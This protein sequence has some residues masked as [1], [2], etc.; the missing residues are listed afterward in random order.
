VH[1]LGQGAH[2]GKVSDIT[3]HNSLMVQVW[4]MLA[5]RDVTLAAQA[6]RAIPPVPSSTTWVTYLRCHDDIGCAIDSGDAAAVGLNGYW[7]QCFLSD[8]YSGVHPGS[9]ARAWCSRPIPSRATAG[10]A[11]AR[12]A[13]PA[14]RR[15]IP[16]RDVDLVIGRLCLAYA[17]VMGWGGIPVIWMGD[18]LATV[19]DPDWAAEPGH[20]TTT[21]G[22]TVR[23]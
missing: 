20:A 6:L 19:N 9:A 22:R 8:Y 4:S 18:E 14:W 1:Y 15:R 13:W 7:H 21:G 2:H 17:I 12:P 23:G 3:Y 16:P 11:A 5:T 10:S